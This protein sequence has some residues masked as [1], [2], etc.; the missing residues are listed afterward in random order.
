MT[1]DDFKRPNAHH[2]IYPILSRNPVDFDNS[3]LFRKPPRTRI[4]KVQSVPLSRNR[5]IFLATNVAI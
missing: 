4:S 1:I 3:L 5:C 2:L